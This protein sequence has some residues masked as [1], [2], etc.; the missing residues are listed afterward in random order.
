VI[1]DFP[2]FGVPG[3]APS[4]PHDPVI[5]ISGALAEALI[6]P[7]SAL[8]ELPRH[9]MAA[10]FHCVAGWTATDLHWEG[11]A[12]A[13]LYHRVIEPTLPAGTSITHVVFGGLDGFRSIVT[14]EDALAPDVLLAEHLN[15]ESLTSDHGAPI[16]LVSPQQYGFV[17]TKH[18]CEI[19]LHTTRPRE[20][21]HPRRRTQLSL[22]LLKP[23]PRAR[24][25]HEERHRYLPG[26]VV[27]PV[28]HTL[29][30]FFRLTSA[31]G[32]RPG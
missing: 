32:G 14:I 4:V 5:T 8:T 7:V 16:R 25:W 28:Y 24:V 19:G 12:F 2:R 23:H 17:S 15:G 11:V 9:K 6:L 31:R 21:Y 10:D 22:Q 26:P 18:L 20:I 1:D 30:R 29:I 3:P 13:D 27:R